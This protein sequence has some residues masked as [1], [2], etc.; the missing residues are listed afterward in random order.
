MHMRL[1][2]FVLAVLLPVTFSAPDASADTAISPG[3]FVKDLAQKAFAS[4]N[5]RN[6]SVADRGRGLDELLDTG[7]DMPQV[8]RYVVGPYWQEAS[9]DE[10]QAFTV[11]FRDYVKRTY[12]ERF[13]EYKADTFRI[14]G[15]RNVNAASSVVSTEI[16]K[17][18]EAEMA[19]RTSTDQPARI[20]W[21]V[22]AGDGYRIVD[23]TVG[24]VSI[25]TTKRAEFLS[26]LRHIG[27]SL[28]S[29][30]QR[31]QATAIARQ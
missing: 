25:A 6:L 2:H 10:Q 22:I 24:G 7:F 26:Y 1:F 3:V 15:Q 28:A 17:T 11:A 30:T 31:L 14:V 16:D 23:V 20:E 27:G 4:A 21:L 12:V 19:D 13:A 18:A 9:A 8:A 5:D 29:L